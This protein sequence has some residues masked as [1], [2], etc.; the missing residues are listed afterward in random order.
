MVASGGDILWQGDYLEEKEAFLLFYKQ[1]PL[2]GTSWDALRL[3]IISSEVNNLND[4]DPAISC[5][6]PSLKASIDVCVH[7]YET[8]LPLP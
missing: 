3:K 4:P 5:G 7:I 2:L 1:P 8:S 6:A